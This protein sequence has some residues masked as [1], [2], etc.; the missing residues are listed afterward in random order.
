MFSSSTI[1]HRA[2]F[3][4]CYN[5]VAMRTYRENGDEVGDGTVRPELVVER[6]YRGVVQ[7]VE[8]GDPSQGQRNERPAVLDTRHKRRCM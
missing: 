6:A 8:G 2:E 3:I 5:V 1:P 7:V 4:H